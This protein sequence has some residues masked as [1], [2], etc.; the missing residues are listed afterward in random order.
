MARK[1]KGAEPIRGGSET[2]RSR[3][4][5]GVVAYFD[6]GEKDSLKAAAGLSG[7]PL[8]HFVR[9][10]ALEAARKALQGIDLK[11]SKKKG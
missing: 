6:D 2:A 3:G 4:L 7:Q 1:A 9:D 11:K 10:S 8:A 5:K